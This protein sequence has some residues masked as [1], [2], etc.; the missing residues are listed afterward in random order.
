MIR[1]A[2]STG[3]M[4]QCPQIELW[5]STDDHFGWNSRFHMSF[6][7]MMTPSANCYSSTI[8]SQ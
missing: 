1:R 7:S 6:V 8:G 5:T 2:L 3:M 4:M